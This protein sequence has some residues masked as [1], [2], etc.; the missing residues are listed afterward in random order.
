MLLLGIL[1]GLIIGL[2]IGMTHS[3][4]VSKSVKAATNEVKTLVDKVHTEVTKFA[5]GN[6]H[7][8]CGRRVS[9]GHW[10]G[11]RQPVRRR[12]YSYLRVQARLQQRRALCQG[13]HRPD[14]LRKAAI[15]AAPEG[16]YG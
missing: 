1:I 2:A 16:G 15:T 6:H 10:A 11:N 9:V 12:R 8:R 14:A 13:A 5:A 4:F 3:A 7:H